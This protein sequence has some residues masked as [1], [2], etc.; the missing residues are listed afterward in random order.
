MAD[1]DLV[2]KEKVEHTGLF[3]FKDF[4]A[5]AHNWFKEERYGVDEE[6]YVEKVKGNK[7]D[8]NI[9]W[10][11]TK[12]VSDYFKIEYR[13][14]FKIIGLTEVEVEIDGEKKQMNQ[15]NVEVEIKGALIRDPQSKYDTSAFNRFIREIYNKYI[16][17]SRIDQNK[18]LIK[19][20]TV[21]FKDELKAFLELSG[22]R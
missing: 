12:E 6:K 8:I 17:P 7:R 2:I 18:D 16:I 1:R 21:K 11:V 10:K 15:G 14:K 22:R 9:E 5:F 20:D 19:D 3:S 13:V 4:Y